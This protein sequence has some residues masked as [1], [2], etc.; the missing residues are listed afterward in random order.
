M[1]IS[2]VF[3][4][5]GC[6]HTNETPWDFRCPGCYGFYNI[7]RV[8]GFNP[9]GGNLPIEEGQLVSL[10]EVEADVRPRTST[11]ISSLDRT[12]GK[13]TLDDS[14]G[15]ADGQIIM[16][17]GNPGSGKST[18][19][20][21]ALNGLAK[22]RYETI[23]FAGEESLEQI[24]ERADRI[25]KIHPFLKIVKET[26]LDAILDI[27]WDR[28]PKMF[29]V[30]SLQKV[31]VDDFMTGSISA[32]G[33]VSRELEK[34]CK[35]ESIAAIFI[36][37]VGKDESFQGPKAIEHG[38]DTSLYLKRIDDAHP[39]ILE[40]AKNRFGSTDYQ[41]KFWM[42]EKG[43]VEVPDEEYNKNE[44]I[45]SDTVAT[46]T[47]NAL[48]VIAIPLDVD[49]IDQ[50]FPNPNLADF[51][52]GPEGEKATAVLAVKCDVDGCRGKI[53]HA[54]TSS[55][56]TRESGFHEARIAK[57]KLKN[58]EDSP[59]IFEAVSTPS[60]DPFDSGPLTSKPRVKRAKKSNIAGG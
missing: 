23:L 6:G 22:Q 50:S 4:C 1:S 16:L 11:L 39:R 27:L 41:P 9:D 43:L 3:K 25:G 54:C 42:T 40:C 49:G 60:L 38:V 21:Q 35:S 52:T 53:D 58:P 56:G 46:Q 17:Y 15:F 32:L 57:S 37:Q 47:A 34:F 55:N 20:L 19:L 18:L 8:P 12:L 29:A 33:I 13:S 24:K 10:C 30:D 59:V 5:R 28:K 45:S 48:P 36:V 51:W 31:D 2:Y 26:H 7:N 44:E 14:R